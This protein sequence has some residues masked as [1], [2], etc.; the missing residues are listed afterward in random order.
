MKTLEEE[1]KEYSLDI[2]EQ[3][4]FTEGAKCIQRWIQVEEQFPP[5]YM[6]IICKERFGY[7][8]YIFLLPNK[9]DE[10]VVKNGITHWRPIERS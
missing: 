3:T 2:T 1:A 6:H 4:I 7:E 10:T 8:C 5:L 9:R